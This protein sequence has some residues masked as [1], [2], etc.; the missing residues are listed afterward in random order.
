MR[1]TTR[2]VDH[3]TGEQVW[4]DEYHTARRPGRW[5]GPLDDIGRVIAA[6]V[7]ADEGILVQLLAAERRKRRPVSVTP[8]GGDAAVLR[9]LPDP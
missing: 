2:L 6:R 8:Y 3:A 9:V 1:V 7:G 5:S 4:G